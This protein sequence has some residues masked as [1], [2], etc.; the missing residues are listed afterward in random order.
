L[1]ALARL[2]KQQTK[3]SESERKTNM[4][5]KHANNCALLIT[6]LCVG[7]S[8]PVLAQN[9][10][11]NGDFETP[12]EPFYTY[13][14]VGSTIPG[15]T[16]MGFPG[17]DVH[18]VSQPAAWWPGNPSQFMDLTGDTGGA[19]VQSDVFT[20]TIGQK[21]EVTFDAFNGSLVYGGAYNGAGF[22]LQA[23]GVP[24]AQ[25]SLAA[26]DGQTL[27]YDFTAIATATTLTFMD[28]SGYD[29][30]AGWI[31]NV[32]VVAAPEPSTIGLLIFAATLAG[33]LGGF[34]NRLTN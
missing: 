20:S 24:L 5:I 1:T 32:S 11:S 2:I 26:G 34:R 25:Y 17:T 13:L 23:T 12:A 3:H 27:T 16:V 31:D 8:A 19:G 33:Y 14:P 21:Y 6:L 28:A 15:W 9:L 7:H 18:H 30:N 10:I 22:T 4:K 29:S